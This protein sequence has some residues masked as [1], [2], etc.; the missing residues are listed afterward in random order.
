MD[1]VVLVLGGF[2][3]LVVRLSVE[4]D[5]GSVLWKICCVVIGSEIPD[6]GRVSELSSWAGTTSG[7]IASKPQTISFTRSSQSSP[8]DE[9]EGKGLRRCYRQIR[10]ELRLHNLVATRTYNQHLTQYI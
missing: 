9:V 1:L 6:T 3:P 4:D 10:F 8:C 7:V 5:F 2:Q